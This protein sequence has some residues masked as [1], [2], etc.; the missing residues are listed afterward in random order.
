M[1]MFISLFT[2]PL[3]WIIVVDDEDLDEL[4]VPGLFTAASIDAVVDAGPRDPEKAA[5]LLL[6]LQSLTP[7]R[8]AH[9]GSKPFI[10]ATTYMLDGCGRTP[11][12]EMHWG[13]LA[14]D[15]VGLGCGCKAHR[16]SFSKKRNMKAKTTRS[17]TSAPSSTRQP[18]HGSPFPRP[19][20]AGRC[21]G[22][23]APG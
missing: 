19:P 21:R 13:R 2:G 14:S 16:W 9:F 5:V 17:G 12:H 22:T 20:E 18:K 11:G 7:P 1:A 3:L 6:R 15:C 23:A 4:V 8:P 10:I